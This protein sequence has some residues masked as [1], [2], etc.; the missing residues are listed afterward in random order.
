MTDKDDGAP[1]VV[2][3]TTDLLSGLLQSKAKGDI[4]DLDTS[5]SYKSLMG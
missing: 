3:D 4:D 1:L 5:T 2:D